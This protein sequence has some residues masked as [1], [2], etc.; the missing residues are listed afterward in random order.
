MKSQVF[1]ADLRVSSG[2]NLLDKIA[3]LLDRTDL[4]EKKIG[5]AHV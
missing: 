5:R 4:R 1:F 3:T 2:K